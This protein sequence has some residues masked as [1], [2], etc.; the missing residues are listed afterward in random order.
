M[1]THEIIAA[2]VSLV[3]VGDNE[4]SLTLLNSLSRKIQR[5]SADGVHDTRAGH[6]VLENR[7]ITPSRL[8]RS[9]AGY[10]EAGHPRNEAV[11]ALKYNKLAG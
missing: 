11:K 9:N 2:E 5:V 1:S 10:L 4:I 3:S 6:H 8:P 7:G